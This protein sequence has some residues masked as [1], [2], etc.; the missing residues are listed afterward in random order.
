MKVALEFK[1]IVKK[2]KNSDLEALNNVSA[3]IFEGEFITILGSSGSGKSTLLKMVNRLIEPTSGQIM[4][5]NQ[6]ISQEDPVLLRRKIGYVIQQVG[7]FPHLTVFENIEMVLKLHHFTR[8]QSESRI[9]ELMTMIGL[10]YVEYKDRYPHQLSGGQQQRVGLAR[11]LAANPDMVLLDEPFASI[12]AI[13]R[14]KLQQD[15][16]AIHKSAQKTFLFVT[17][18]VNE[19][20]LLGTRVMIMDE[21]QI[22]QFDT[23]ENIIKHPANEFVSRLIEIAQKQVEVLKELS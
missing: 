9:Q 2:Y 14:L 5:F 7:L 15:I 11:G 13:N 16:L 12:D 20:L 1:N 18:D 8:D 21:G 17:H 22:Q 23:P 4:F 3:Q 6:D 10:D 19:A